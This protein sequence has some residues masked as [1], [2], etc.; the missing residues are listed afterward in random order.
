MNKLRN[1]MVKETLLKLPIRIFLIMNALAV[2]YPLLWNLLA[3]FKTNTEI[4][5]DPWKLPKGLYF[6]NYAN[7]FSKAKM[8]DYFMNSV[9]VVILALVLL[10][11]FAIPISYVLAK[12]KFRFS[13]VLKNI[14]MGCIFIQATYIIVPLFLTLNDFHMLDSRTS[15]SLIYAVFQFP[16]AIFLLTGYIKAIPNDY[17]QAAMIDGCSYY[18]ILLKIIVP[19]AKP[20]IITISMLAVLGFWNEYPQAL[21]FITTESKKTLPVGLVNLFEVQRYATDWGALFAALIII[22]VPTLM[23][24]IAGQKR[25]TQGMNIGGLKG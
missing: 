5:G 9:F 21:T 23:L 4:L 3:S 16:F 13:G 25:L 17:E 14:Y 19:M 24:Y 22:L 10:L 8:G 12:F 2:I 11:L 7:A 1:S 20:G 6:E 18:R 15:L